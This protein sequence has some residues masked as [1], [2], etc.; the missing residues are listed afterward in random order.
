MKEAIK[1]LLKNNFKEWQGISTLMERG[2]RK[3]PIKIECS[4]VELLADYRDINL[5]AEEI[6]EVLKK[7]KIDISNVKAFSMLGEYITVQI[8]EATPKTEEVIII[9]KIINAI[10][11]LGVN[12]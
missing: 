1:S 2:W 12:D 6:E 11:C 5:L 10:M 8:K 4:I 3:L 9:P 7:Y